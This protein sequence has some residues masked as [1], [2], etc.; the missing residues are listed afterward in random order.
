MGGAPTGF[1]HVGGGRAD[2]AKSEQR[3]GEHTGGIKWQGFGSFGVGRLHVIDLG[4]VQ[5][6]AVDVRDTSG[7]LTDPSSATL[8]LTL[9]DGSTLAPAVPLPSA[10]SGELRVDYV[11]TQVGRHAW[12]MVTSNPTTAYTDVFD[13]RP[14]VPV[15][16]VSLA[17]ARAQLNLG[18]T[19]TADDDEL[20]SFIGAAT[21]AV[22]RA[23]GRAVVR[24]TVVERHEVCGTVSDLLL[25]QV[26]VLSLT[27]VVSA[28]SS[29]TWIVSNLRVDSDTGLVT[30]TAGDS[31]TGPL[32]VTYQVGY[33]IIPDDY[34]LAALIIIQHLW[35]TQRGAMGTVPGGSEESTFMAGRGFAIPRRALELLD[36]PLPGV[37]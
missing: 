6:I 29:A 10:V 2:G 36:T 20:R 34:L 32:D 4:A 9:P 5:Q 31:F 37:A 8:T 26:P 7:T 3:R 11:T 16:I 21:G 28:D 30:V 15:G 14:A 12:R 18:A 27:S 24:R 22:E 19:E 25:R 23:L 1:G 13:V 35:E 33:A 17:D